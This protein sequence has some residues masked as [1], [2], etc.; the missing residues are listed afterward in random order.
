MF[1]PRAGQQEMVPAPIPAC[2]PQNSLS[3]VAELRPTALGN[4]N[5]GRAKGLYSGDGSC[6]GCGCGPRSL[7][8]CW[9]S[10]AWPQHSQNCSQAGLRLP[11]PIGAMEPMELG[12]NRCRAGTNWAS[13]SPNWASGGPLHAL[14]FLGWERGRGSSVLSLSPMGLGAALSPILKQAPSW[15][16]PVG[17]GAPTAGSRRSF[18]TA[19][20]KLRHGLPE[21]LQPA[22]STARPSP[23]TARCRARGPGAALKASPQTQLLFPE[24]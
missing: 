3:R 11:R 24:I 21:T 12:R 1:A 5:L 17:C 14:L 8:P 18:L 2:E 15:A 9:Q 4:G 22:Q 23:G 19:R 20:G 16:Q 6:L 10:S 7:E 13:V